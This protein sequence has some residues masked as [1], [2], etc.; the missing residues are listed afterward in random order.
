MKITRATRGQ[1]TRGKKTD[2]YRVSMRCKGVPGAIVALMRL[3]SDV[4]NGWFMSSATIDRIGGR[5]T[6]GRAKGAGCALYA[7]YF[8]INASV[9]LA[10]FQTFA[11]WKTMATE[12][13]RLAQLP[14]KSNP[15]PQPTPPG[16]S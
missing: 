15:L 4:P 8:P 11:E 14:G 10:C 16:K 7:T 13:E 1:N 6:L 3:D 12:A 2:G 9:K 5:T